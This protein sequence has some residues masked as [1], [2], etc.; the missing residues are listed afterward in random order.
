M[1]LDARRSGPLALRIAAPLLSRDEVR[2][3]PRSGDTVSVR[4]S[5]K[6]EVRSLGFGTRDRDVL[7]FRIVLFL[8]SRHRV[9]PRG[10]P[11]DSERSVPAC[12]GVMRRLQHDE[13]P[14]HPGMDIALHRNEFGLIPFRID[15]RRTRRL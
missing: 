5:S 14:V 10:Q 15:W 3:P 13:V 6:N 11:R 9:L 4:S 8:P 1:R 12:D 7:R 2:L